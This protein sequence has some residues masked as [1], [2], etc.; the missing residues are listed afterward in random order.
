MS[1]PPV[2]RCRDT[3]TG[4]SARG[5][6]A[7]P[8]GFGCRGTSLVVTSRLLTARE[9]AEVLGVCAETVLRWIRAG[10]LPAVR[11]PGGATRIVGTQLEAWLLSRATPA[12]G[13]LATT[14]SA[15]AGESY[16]RR[17]TIVE[18]ATKRPST[19][20]ANPHEE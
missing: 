1:P 17:G 7:A 13:V 2:S 5:P 8:V 9:V 16:P 12:L 3:R 14:T 18:L 4:R 15:A 6:G 11:L 10:E 20:S 19:K